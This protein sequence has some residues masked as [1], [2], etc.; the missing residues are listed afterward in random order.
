MTEESA[1]WLAVGGA[2]YVF[3]TVFYRAEG[4]L[5][6]AHAI[7]HV[8]VLAGAFGVHNS[9]LLTLEGHQASG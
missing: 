1:S 4:D 6:F 8:F 9:I 3:G 5:P 7:W 2:A